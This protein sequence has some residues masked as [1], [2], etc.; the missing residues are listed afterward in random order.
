MISGDIITRVRAVIESGE[1]DDE[2]FVELCRRIAG[3]QGSLGAESGL[4]GVVPVPEEAFK[5]ATVAHFPV[6]Q[7][8]AVFRTSGTTTGNTGKHH[9][10]DPGLYRASVLGGF[11][12][13]VMYP[14]APEGMLSL[15][16]DA[17]QRPGSSLSHMVSIVA[18]EIGPDRS[19]IA[20]QGDALLV[21]AVKDWLAAAQ[22]AGRPVVIMGTSLDFQALFQALRDEGG[23]VF[24][25]PGSSRAM[26]TGGEKA[27]GREVSRKELWDGFSGLLGIES[28]DAVEEFGMTELMSQAYDSPRV[29]MGPRRFVPVPWMRTRVLEPESMADVAPGGRGMLCH[30]DIAN[31]HTAVAV[32]TNDLAIR[33]EDGFYAIRRAPG[34]L[35]R[36]CSSEAASEEKKVRD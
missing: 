20:R 4:Q 32:L 5:R 23:T 11:R 27:S 3:E 22:R 12:R 26:H 35:P 34:A 10:F 17:A 31:C 33:V 15:I 19:V 16:P 9:V 25:L 21:D 29:T 30:Y 24:H 6:D 2:G 28:D 8:Q 18:D 14:P 1:L 36:G 13:F 7:A